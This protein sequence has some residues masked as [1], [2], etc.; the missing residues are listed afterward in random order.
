MGNDPVDVA[1]LE[2][3][4]AQGLLDHR[5]R[6]GEVGGDDLVLHFGDVPEGALGDVAA[7]E[8]AIPTPI[9]PQQ[10]GARG[11]G[12]DVVDHLA[13]RMRRELVCR[14]AEGRPQVRLG[15]QHVPADPDRREQRGACLLIDSD[16]GGAGQSELGLDPGHGILEEIRDVGHVERSP[17]GRRIRG[18]RRA[19]S[20][21]AGVEDHSDLVGVYARIIEEI[22]DRP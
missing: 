2:T 16:R 11:I 13:S 3:G 4:P 18:Q 20:E 22:A 5:P 21:R 6:R 10:R 7:R 8:N 9:L 17:I 14:D 1:Q 15:D 12:D 19:G